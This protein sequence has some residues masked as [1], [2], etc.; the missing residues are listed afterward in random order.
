M[1]SIRHI[2]IALLCITLPLGLMSPAASAS[3]AA[4]TQVGKSDRPVGESYQPARARAAGAAGVRGAVVKVVVGA[5]RAKVVTFGGVSGLPR[6]GVAQI[7]A[8]VSA[9]SMKKGSVSIRPRSATAAT[10]I[11]FGPR[12]TVK[13]AVKRSPGS[14]RGW[15]IRNNGTRSVNVTI[16]VTGHTLH[17]PDPI[18]DD[19][20]A[21]GGDAGGGGNGGGTDGADPTPIDA[22]GRYDTGD[23]T[24][25]NIY[26]NPATGND[27][28]SGV[29]AGHPLRTIAAAWNRIPANSTLT[30]GRRIQLAPGTYASG[31]MPH[32]W[33][34]RRGTYANPIILNATAGPGTAILQGD[35]NLFGSSYVY[36]VGLDIQRNGDAFHCEQCSNILIRQTNMNGDPTPGGAIAHETIKINQ[37]DHVFI[38]DSVI[39]GA[40]DNAVDF[41]A[42]Q[43]GHL[44][45]NR[46]SN[47]ESWCAYAKGGSAYLT[48]AGNEIFD[49]GE[50]GFTAGQGAGIEFTTSPW[51]TYEAMDIKVVNN[52]IHDVYGAGLGVNG[53]YN[54]LMAYNTVYRV[55]ERSHV[56][57]FVFGLHSCD[58]GND[59]PRC[60]AQ[61]NSGGWGVTGAGE[62]Y[63]PNRHV[64]FYNNVLLNP[65]GY[66][67][68][69]QHFA[70]AGPR[71]QPDGATGPSPALAD[72]DLRIAGNVIWNG[73]PSMPLGFEDDGGCQPSNPT[74][75]VTLVR[76]DNRINNEQP[77]FVDAAGLNFVP[78]PGGALDSR[79][80]VPIPS[81]DWTDKPSPAI[82]DGSTSNS[83]PRNCAGDPRIGWGR[84]GAY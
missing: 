2:L 72:A 20:G 64:Y 38:E 18:G 1:R 74:C 10:V 39:A 51:I 82:P 69:W 59:E 55:G 79:A 65:A 30:V 47:S 16:A 52:I 58:G 17:N 37:S 23:F 19:G 33:E 8:T 78:A 29:D 83:I 81:F 68:Q 35:V 40:D 21:D 54:I 46:I 34:N 60:A 67:S 12:R 5:G 61:I 73:G 62:A 71:T 57:E 43:Y 26:V 27:G 66:Q 32:Y 22:D 80:G 70:V 50:G 24:G 45:G 14:P 75:N 76:A 3:A 77:T 63:I 44:L 7:R 25:T 36:F 31:D 4:S 9:R 41:V 42:V 53:G 49:C 84:P 6:T 48:V 13:K 56:V 15:L 28:N 11:K